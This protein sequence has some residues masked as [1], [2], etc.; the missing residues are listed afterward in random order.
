[1]TPVVASPKRS[2]DL[3]RV[4]VVV[5]YLFLTGVVVGMVGVV[6]HWLAWP[7]ITST[8]G[9]TAYMFA[10]HPESETCRLRN[11]VIG[12]TVAVGAG[13]GSLVVFGLLHHASVSTTGAPTWSQAAGAATA[14]G[15]TVAVLE[16]FGSHHAP[17]AATALLIATG[18][19]KP[20]AP[21]IGLVL[22]LAIVIALGPLL[23]RVPFA[24]RASTADQAGSR[25]SYHDRGRALS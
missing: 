6:G 8:V 11:A 18:L 15:V 22:G 20:G 17:A 14:A 12:H 9:P 21:L 3:V 2:H 19:V 25:F 13:L 10:A 16:V 23:G 5:R 4:E 24:R 1:V 7:L